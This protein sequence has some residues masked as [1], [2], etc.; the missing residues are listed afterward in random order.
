MTSRSRIDATTALLA[1]L[2]VGLLGSFSDDLLGT[3]G[4]VEVVQVV[5]W[6]A[7]AALVVTA[8]IGMLGAGAR[9]GRPTA[10]R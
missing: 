1:G 6:I 10:A 3:S 9:H 8:L 5:L 7:S 2:V 4:V